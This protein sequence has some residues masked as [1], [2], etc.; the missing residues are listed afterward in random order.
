LNK[1]LSVVAIAALALAF[2]ATANAA[3]KKGDGVANAGPMNGMHQPKKAVYQKRLRTICGPR[4]K[5]S[6]AC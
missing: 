2:S 3:T 4:S 6:G 1:V 5:M